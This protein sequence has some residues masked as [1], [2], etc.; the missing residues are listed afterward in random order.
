MHRF[1]HIYSPGL[2]VP[3]IDYQPAQPVQY[4]QIIRQAP[5]VDQLWSCS[6]VVWQMNCNSSTD[7]L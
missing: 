7:V 4:R 5:D 2:P 3:E 6:I 1:L